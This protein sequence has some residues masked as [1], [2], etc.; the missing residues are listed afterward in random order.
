MSIQ[1]YVLGFLF[2]PELSLVALIRKQRPEWQRGKLNGI[3]GKIESGE[4]PADAMRREFHEE[5]GVDFLGWNHFTTMCGPDWIVFVFC[6]ADKSVLAV[7]SITD[8][9]VTFKSPLC[10]NE[11]CA[12]N[13]NWLISMART[14]LLE[15]S[16][17]TYEVFESESV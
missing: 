9:E 17:Q 2:S 8:E 5:T 12:H 14:Q 7:D 1:Q 4:K 6:G 16:K 15:G 10:F 3:G 13:V 11:G